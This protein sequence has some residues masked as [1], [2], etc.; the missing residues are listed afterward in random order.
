M[1]ILV[2]PA[3]RVIWP[4]RDTLRS[5]TSSAQLPV[6]IPAGKDDQHLAL[7]SVDETVLL[8][9]PARPAASE[10]FTQGFWL[11][12]APKGITQSRLD[13]LVD[14]P[15]LLAVLGL[16]MEVVLLGGWCP[17]QPLSFRH[18]PGPDR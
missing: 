7:Q 4:R 15:E 11:A 2:M 6:V 16:P 5:Q 17:S 3:G 14:P 1:T 9:D 13:Q 18:Q 10:I 12:D 8:V